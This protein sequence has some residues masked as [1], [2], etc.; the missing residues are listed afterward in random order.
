MLG[1]M[2]RSEYLAEVAAAL[3]LKVVPWAETFKS[4]SQASKGTAIGLHRGYLVAVALVKAGNARSVGI[5]IRYPRLADISSLQKDLKE[6]P[7]LRSFTSKKPLKVASDGLTAGWSYALKKPKVPELAAFVDALI[8]TVSRYTPAFDGRCEECHAN[9]TRDI[10]LFNRIPGFH[11]STCQQRIAAANERAAE[12]YA[13]RDANYPTAF[14]T[15]VLA[16][17]VAGAAWGGFL[18][19][20]DAGSKEWNP[21][22]HALGAAWIGFAVC[23]LMKK[24]VERLTRT[25][26]VI[27]IVTTLAGKFWADT[28]YFAIVIGHRQAMPLKQILPRIAPHILALKTS[29]AWGIFILLADISLSV[30]LPW[31]PWGR[32]PKFEAVFQPVSPALPESNPA[33]TP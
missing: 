9:P 25:S 22:F 17:A 15:A 29:S 2:A 21:I 18:G 13:Q 30:A 19:A 33:S 6:Q 12:E 3:G 10:V 24:S 14:V 32:L 27:A 11:C 8:S 26:Q 1:G 7:E 5:M 28:L 20:I 31:T 23:Y 4:D 16:A